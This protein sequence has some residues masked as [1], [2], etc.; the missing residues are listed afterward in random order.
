MSIDLDKLTPAPWTPCRHMQSAS[1]NAF[2]LLAPDG[3]SFCNS[4]TD[5]EFAALARRAFDGD[6]EALA[7]WEANRKKPDDANQGSVGGA[8]WWKNKG[9]I[10]ALAQEFADTDWLME[11]QL[12]EFLSKPWLWTDEYR[13]FKKHGT[14]CG[15]P[16]K[17]S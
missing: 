10:L 6:P 8:R 3:K 1:S 11:G 2:S 7:W 16:D 4:K 12:F 15:F 13:F 5:M 9:E 14:I 17:R